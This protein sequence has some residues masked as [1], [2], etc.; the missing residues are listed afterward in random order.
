MFRISSVRAEGG[1]SLLESCRTVDLARSLTAF[2]VAAGMPHDPREGGAGRVSAG[3]A[4][5]H[6]ALSGGTLPHVVFQ[7]GPC[8]KILARRY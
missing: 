4:G 6:D 8:K 2:S 3:M 5:R 7:A 1:P